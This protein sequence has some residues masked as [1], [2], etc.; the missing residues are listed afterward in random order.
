MKKI[1]SVFMA[2]VLLFS[3]A[4]CGG[5]ETS[6]A[7]PEVSAGEADTSS[8]APGSTAS[9]SGPAA[10]KTGSKSLVVY[11]SRSG[12]TETVARSIQS[13]T[14]ADIFELVPAVPYSD[15]YDAVLAAAQAEQNEN[16]RPAIANSVEN[17]AD[18][19]IIYVGFPIWYGDMPMLLYTFFDSYDFSGK[20][21]APFCTSGGSGLSGTV[22]AI[23]ELEPDAAVTDG[24]HIRSGASSV[25][26]QAVS[27]WLSEIGVEP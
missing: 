5:S 2:F 12:N 15:D 13:Q 9:V 16:A 11:F 3:L 4:A 8:A 1:A 21:V 17:I 25:P 10:A 18:Y 24:L 27:E 20:T 14:G 6:P 19:D 26:D 7:S 22:E 23:K